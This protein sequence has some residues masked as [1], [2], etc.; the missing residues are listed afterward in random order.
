M[1]CNTFAYAWHEHDRP[2][3]INNGIIVSL[4]LLKVSNEEKNEVINNNVHLY[5]QYVLTTVFKK[6]ILNATFK[7]LNWGLLLLQAKLQNSIT[8]WVVFLNPSR[9]AI[10][11]ALV[12]RNGEKRFPEKIKYRL[13]LGRHCCR[14][15]V[16]G[17]CMGVKRFGIGPSPPSRFSIKVCF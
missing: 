14:A 15:L 11:L 13:S 4:H 6:N 9:F 3:R 1:N 10:L 16:Q 8:T 17:G 7:T 2:G 5:K 12:Q